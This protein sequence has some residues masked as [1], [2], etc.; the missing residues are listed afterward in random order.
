LFSFF[1]PII[2]STKNRVNF[3]RLPSSRIVV[4]AS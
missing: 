1:A 4:I 3:I 2:M